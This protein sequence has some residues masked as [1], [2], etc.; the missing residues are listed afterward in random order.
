MRLNASHA[1]VEN[2]VSNLRCL[3]L[4]SAIS[5][6]EASAESACRLGNHESTNAPIKVLGIAT[7]CALTL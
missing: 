7:G 3:H 4:D 5:L 2:A 1:A 6:H